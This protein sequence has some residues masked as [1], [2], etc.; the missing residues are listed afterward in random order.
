[1]HKGRGNSNKLMGRL[2][3]ALKD[4]FEIKL[5]HLEGGSKN[6]AIPREADVIFTVKKED[7][8]NVKALIKEFEGI[9]KHELKV[10][11]PSV[12]LE[13]TE[14]K[15]VTEN[16]TLKA[17]SEVIDVL[18]LYPNGINSMSMSM[19][20]LVESSTNL[21][22]VTTTEDSV[23]FDSAVRSS[24]KSLKDEITNRARAL[25]ELVSGEFI[26]TSSYPEWEYDS[27]SKIRGLCVDVYE[28]MNGKKPE[29]VAIH[30]GVECG[31]FNERLGNLDMISFGPNLYDVHT[32]NEHMS[33]KSV[34]N[35]WEYLLE[36][37]KNIK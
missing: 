35:V 2:L 16:F 34:Q 32:P 21:G 31:L 33:I 26:V 23:V 5:V 13:V 11:D 36:V 8:E 1:I 20:G 9:F 3:K 25:T 6:N 30:A 29:I 15:N 28:K 18:Y 24:V 22:V 4:K 14:A 12:T 17:T 19:D 37:L 10:S 7:L 27:D